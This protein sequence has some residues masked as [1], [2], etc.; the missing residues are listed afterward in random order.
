ML[1][2]NARIVG[3]I[4]LKICEIC[5]INTATLRANLFKK[6]NTIYRNILMC[7]PCYHGVKEC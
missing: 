6:D 5:K 1:G 3:D 2:K 7:E 4:M